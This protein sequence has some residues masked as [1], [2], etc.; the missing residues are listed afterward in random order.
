MRDLDAQFCELVEMCDRFLDPFTGLAQVEPHL[1]GLFDL[2]VV[3]TLPAT[4]LTK[5]VEFVA[6]FGAVEN[7]ARIG[8]TCHQPQR[9][10]LPCT[11]DQDRWMEPAQRLR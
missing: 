3:P 9:L 10:T 11:T 2:G 5:H 1:N 4:V 6:E 8:I 7:I